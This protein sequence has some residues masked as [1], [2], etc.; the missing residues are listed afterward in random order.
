MVICVNKEKYKRE[1][2]AILRRA[3]IAAKSEYFSWT[4]EEQEKYTS[5]AL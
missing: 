3:I 2:E 1:Q 5:K 4:E